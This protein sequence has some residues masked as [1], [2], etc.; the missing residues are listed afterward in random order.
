[1]KN[2]NSIQ[3][4]DNNT[5]TFRE[6][7]PV[8]ESMNDTLQVASQPLDVCRSFLAHMMNKQLKEEHMLVQYF[9]W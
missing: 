9:V 5:I 4:F 6:E 7:L 1:M 2:L 8:S 3:I